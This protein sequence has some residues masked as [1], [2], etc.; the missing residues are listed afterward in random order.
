M[1]VNAEFVVSRDEGVLTLPAEF[2][3]EKNGI[4][5]VYLEPE[6]SRE[7]IV[8]KGNNTDVIIVNGLTEGDVV[9]FPPR[10]DD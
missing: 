9:L 4:S 8:G 1:T 6:T 3:Q 2:I 5:R 10:D 7:V